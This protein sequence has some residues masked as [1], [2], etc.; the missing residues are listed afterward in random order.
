M[1]KERLVCEDCD[2]RGTYNKALIAKNPF[3]PLDELTGCPNCKSVNRLR[4]TCDEP[5]CWEPATIGTP[6]KG[7][8]RRTCWQH[9]PITPE[10]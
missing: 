7:G 8:Y 10:G 3:D 2:W 4:G 5:G 6:V 9:S 1:E